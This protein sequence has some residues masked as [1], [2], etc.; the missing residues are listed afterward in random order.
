[1]RA[2]PQ[3]MFQTTFFQWWFPTPLQ[4]LLIQIICLT[5]LTF[6]LIFFLPILVW[7][8]SQIS[9]SPVMSIITFIWL[10]R[11]PFRR[12]DTLYFESGNRCY[13]MTGKANFFAVNAFVPLM[14]ETYPGRC[15]S[16]IFKSWLCCVTG[17]LFN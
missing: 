8:F 9:Q 7:T 16:G 13:F 14:I 11:V 5:D 10:R 3:T 15:E 12:I 2:L 17:W 6:F 1:M 4:T